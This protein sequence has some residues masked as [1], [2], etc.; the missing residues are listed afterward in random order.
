MKVSH[1]SVKAAD[2]VKK[3][4]VPQ[5]VNALAAGKLS[6]S[7]AARIAKL[8]VEQQEAVV[9]AIAGGLKPKQALAQVQGTAA[10]DQAAL[11]DDDGQPVPE[12]VMP[13][14]RQR[15]QLRALCRRLEALSQEVRHLGSAPVGVHLDVQRVLTSLEE[16]RRALLAGEPVRLCRHDPGYELRCDLCRGHGWLPAGVRELPT[17][18]DSQS[19]GRTVGGAPRLRRN[20]DSGV[21]A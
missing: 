5:L 9:T 3:Q 16:A 1:F 4:G 13:A 17:S 15:E 8:P 2:K 10:N 11:A 14:F 19:R 7:A 6:V 21:P 20:H 18:P 12:G